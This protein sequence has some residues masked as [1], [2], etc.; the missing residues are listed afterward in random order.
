MVENKG[1]ESLE[2]ESKV[3]GGAALWDGEDR[4]NRIGG[5]EVVSPVCGLLYLRCL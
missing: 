2:L 1:K 4:R 3:D 5:K